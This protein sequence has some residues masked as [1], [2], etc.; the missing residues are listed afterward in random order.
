[1]IHPRAGVLFSAQKNIFSPPQKYFFS[2]VENIFGGRENSQ[3]GSLVVVYTN[4]KL[5]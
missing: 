5:E 3:D 4:P 1:M 2:A